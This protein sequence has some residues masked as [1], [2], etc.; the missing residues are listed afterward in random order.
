[1]KSHHLILFDPDF[2]EEGHYL[3]LKKSLEYVYPYFFHYTNYNDITKHQFKDNVVYT[4]YIFVFKNPE[5]I[6]NLVIHI[7]NISKKYMIKINL[8]INIWNHTHINF[9]IDLKTKYSNIIIISDYDFNSFS[10]SDSNYYSKL[11]I[12]R[13]SP[14]ILISTSD[15]QNNIDI[16]DIID[17]NPINLKNYVVLH[18]FNFNKHNDCQRWLG[19][20][21]ILKI[22]EYL[23]VNGKNL[24]LIEV[25][26][27]NTINLNIEH[28]IDN[29][30]SI[31]G[32]ITDENIFLS[33]MKY[34]DYVIVYSKGNFYKH[35]SSGRISEF[36]FNNIKFITNLPIDKMNNISCKD[37]TYINNIEDIKNIKDVVIAK[38]NIDKTTWININFRKLIYLLS[39]S[40]LIN[41]DTI[42]VNGNSPSLQEKHIFSKNPRI[43]MNLAYRYWRENNCFPEIYISLDDV[44]TPHH[45]DDIHD[46]IENN[47][48]KLFILHTNYFVKYPDDESK[49]YVFN[50]DFLKNNI[51][52]LN[53]SPH[54]TT[55]IMSV[56]LAIIMG[57]KN[58]NIN[59]MDGNYINYLP[60]IEKKTHSDYKKNILYVKR[61]IDKNPNYFFDYYQQVGDIFNI[62]NPEKSYFCKCSYHNGSFTNQPLHIYV[63]NILIHD[64][65]TFG[66]KHTISE[67]RLSI[68]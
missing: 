55:G 33:I 19:Q 36:L 64:L 9:L 1:M 5:A 40:D 45:S 8:M 50:F 26:Y 21:N 22:A 32:K 49:S 16:I 39:F 63:K 35:R 31:K 18:T 3:K 15:K 66:F 65:N 47:K 25:S 43:G 62:P 68:I 17:D 52:L 53:S 7:N 46:M 54:I 56:R 4:I 14:P 30:Y 37:I 38:S 2:N 13:I 23:K 60:E 57:F 44:V 27:D 10:N 20:Y 6:N 42:E 51:Y 34:S 12:I 58:I 67:N 59:G 61:N 24:L 41:N 29:I 28:I 48:C 11:P